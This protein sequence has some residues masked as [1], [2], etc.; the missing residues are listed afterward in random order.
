M[1]DSERF[2]KKLKNSEAKRS[3]LMKA[4][5]EMTLLFANTEFLT[6]MVVSSLFRLVTKETKDADVLGPI[7]V[8][9]LDMQ[10]KMNLVQMMAERL[11]S[12]EFTSRIKAWRQAM[13]SA[14]SCRNKL[15]HGLWMFPIEEGPVITTNLKR[16]GKFD[17][18]QDVN[19]SSIKEFCAEVGE[20][21]NDLIQCL[22]DLG[23]LPLVK[24][25]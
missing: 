20:L 25:E 5:G 16:S 24:D 15:T 21:N 11:L 9:Q 10:R 8:S 23:G 1:S 14:V 17:S 12:D 7:I 2:E 6:N 22:K 18:F 4:L 19:P 13:E 3:E